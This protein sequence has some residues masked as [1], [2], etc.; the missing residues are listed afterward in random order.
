MS[1]ITLAE[2]SE[3][4]LEAMWKRRFKREQPTVFVAEQ[5]GTVVGW[6]SFS[7]SEGVGEVL[8]LYVDPTVWSAGVGRRLLA[9]AL[10]SLEKTGGGRVYLWVLAGNERARRFYEAAGFNRLEGEER[11]TE[12]HG[13]L[14]T[15][16]K[17]EREVA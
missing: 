16:V 2:L 3:V 7:V 4:A 15:E 1:E 9:H 17:Y 13:S 6:V 8:G 10:Q 14:L 11:V 12:R 5:E